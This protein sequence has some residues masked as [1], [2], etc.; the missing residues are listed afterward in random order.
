MGLLTALDR[1]LR[2][3]GIPMAGV[4]IQDDTNK[5]TWRVDFLPGATDPQKQQAAS[6]IANFDPLDP[7]VLAA[8]LE[9]IALTD[10]DQN[11]VIQAVVMVMWKYLAAGKPTLPALGQEIRQKYKTL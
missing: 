9:A 11:K 7:A 2:Q 5:A 10:I 3:A 8:E 4:S 1:V 6:I